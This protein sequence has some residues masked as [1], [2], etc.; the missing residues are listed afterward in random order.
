VDNAGISRRGRA[1]GVDS[2]MM[3]VEPIRVRPRRTDWAGSAVLGERSAMARE[4]ADL[5]ASQ[6]VGTVLPWSDREK[7][8]NAAA[9]Q[10][11]NRFEA[12][13]IIAAV[14]HQMGIG[15]KRGEAK[16]SRF[17]ARFAAGVAMFL[18]IQAGII[19]AVWYCLS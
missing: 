17:S 2:K 15:R 14:Q 8:I 11:I 4:F 1:D 10:G 7:L 6:L 3:Q 18:V 9:M 5:V 12:N 13:L 16:R 19:A